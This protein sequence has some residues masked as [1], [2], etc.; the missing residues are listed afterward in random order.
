MTKKI[1]FLLFFFFSS[2]F[3]SHFQ[4]VLVLYFLFTGNHKILTKDCCRRGDKTRTS[5]N[6]NC[7][8]SSSSNE[9]A[10]LFTLQQF[11]D[12]QTFFSNN[13]SI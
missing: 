13:I 1:H 4:Y 6:W 10:K 2:S 12:Q 5:K 7:L 9:L 8:D 3:S 11:S